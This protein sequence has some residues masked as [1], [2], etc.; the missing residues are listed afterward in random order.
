ME[1]ENVLVVRGLGDGWGV[2]RKSS[3]RE[4]VVVVEMSWLLIV[5]VTGNAVK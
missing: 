1:V 5:V 4:I 2:T 3:R